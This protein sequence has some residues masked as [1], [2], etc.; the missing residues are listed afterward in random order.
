MKAVYGKY[1][2][3]WENRL[4]FRATDR[5]VRPFEWG[6]EFASR[7]PLSSPIIRNG[8]S[9][10]EYLAE[11]NDAAVA[12]SDTFYGYEPSTDYRLEDGVL[13]FTSPVHTPWQE[14][15]VVH[16]QWFPAAGSRRAVVVL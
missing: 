2:E 8:H 4:C 15:N 1:M 6:T 11:V 16:A 3:A 9:D 12:D 7:W 13:K 10:E 14:N 5:V